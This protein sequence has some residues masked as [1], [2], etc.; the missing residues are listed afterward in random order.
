LT[1]PLLD[2]LLAGISQSDLNDA[3]ELAR[4][5]PSK[6][7]VAADATGTEPEASSEP[8]SES[9]SEAQG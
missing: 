2:T 8:S 7:P 6:P 4:F 3:E 5:W 9:S 1:D